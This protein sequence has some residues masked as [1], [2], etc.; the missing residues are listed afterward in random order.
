MVHS[1]L[2][3]KTMIYH[4][5]WNYQNKDAPQGKENEDARRQYAVNMTIGNCKLMYERVKVYG[6]C[7]YFQ[8]KN[9][10]SKADCSLTQEMTDNNELYNWKIFMRCT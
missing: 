9:Y 3:D 7:N 1:R 10:G 5:S 6:V 8:S 2:R 4:F